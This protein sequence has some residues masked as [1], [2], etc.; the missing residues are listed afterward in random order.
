ML[1]GNLLTISRE[2]QV[3]TTSY[4]QAE[5]EHESLSYPYATSPDFNADLALWAAQTVYI[6]A[7][8]M[9][10]RENK[11]KELSTLL[12]SY[13][14]HIT[15]A[16]DMLSADVTLRFLPAIIKHLHLIDPEDPLIP[17]LEEHL[18]TWHYSG[19]SYPL[20]T[21]DL[22]FE[23]IAQNKCLQKMYTDRVITYKN[24]SLAQHPI[25]APWVKACLGIYAT[26]FWKEI[27]QEHTQE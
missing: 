10:Y 26:E 25:I 3:L 5:Y 18:K 16:D 6:A 19:I 11:A 14:G 23:N 22:S 4:L 21:K 2:E 24:M 1:Y 9:L 13:S 15:N 20:E 8:L 17:I 27:K 7:Q 12:P